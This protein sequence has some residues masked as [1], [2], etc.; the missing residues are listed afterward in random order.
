M[1]SGL[2]RLQTSGW[3]IDFSLRV[4]NCRSENRPTIPGKPLVISAGHMAILET[5]DIRTCNFAKGDWTP[6]CLIAPTMVIK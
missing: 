3:T 5:E 2:V 1:G 6:P 4:V